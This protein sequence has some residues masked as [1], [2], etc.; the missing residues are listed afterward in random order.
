VAV[1]LIRSNETMYKAAQL[2]VA[3][4]KQLLVS[5]PEAKKHCIRLLGAFEYRNHMCLVFEPM[6]G[7]ELGCCCSR[8]RAAGL[9]GMQQACAASRGTALPRHGG[10]CPFCP[11]LPAHCRQATQLASQLAL[12]PS[13]GAQLPCA[14]TGL[15]P[16]LPALLAGHEPA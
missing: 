7:A 10:R 3:I 9:R 14:H 4:L 6:V 16:P 8:C 12:P 1:K 2:E 11:F 13:P 5:D 15:C